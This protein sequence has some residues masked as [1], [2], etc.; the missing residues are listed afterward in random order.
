MIPNDSSQTNVE[1]LHRTLL[2]MWVAM[3]MSVV[4]FLVV[5]LLIPSKVEGSSPVPAMA[6]IGM[7]LLNVVLSF[8][9]KQSFLAK[10]VEK[11]ELKL[12][13]QAYLLAFALCESAALFGLIIHFAIG[14]IYYLVAIGIGIIGLVLHFP[15]KQHLLAATSFKKL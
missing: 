15:Q 13:Q 11:Q 12:V 5:T 8:V 6:A 2:I 7:G 3:L 14:S 4:G 10:A 1:A 9:L